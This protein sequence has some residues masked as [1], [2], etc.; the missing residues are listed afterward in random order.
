MLVRS[1]ERWNDT[2][3]EIERKS[4]NAV[5]A[6]HCK[7]HVG[8]GKKPSAKCRFCTLSDDDPTRTQGGPGS[9]S[10]MGP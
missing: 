7:S 2:Q 1:W 9:D 5:Y 8:K 3:A 4:A 6:N 10:D